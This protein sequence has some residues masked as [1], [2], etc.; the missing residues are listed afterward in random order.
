MVD[1]SICQVHVQ[2]TIHHPQSIERCQRQFYME[3]RWFAV[4][5]LYTYRDFGLARL[6][7]HRY[8]GTYDTGMM[9]VI[10]QYP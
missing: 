6:D 9:R 1:P 8:I 3:D 10:V 4:S 2:D 7:T 5:S